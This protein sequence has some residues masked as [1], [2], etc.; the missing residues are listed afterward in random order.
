MTAPDVY[1][2]TWTHRI[3]PRMG[4]MIPPRFATCLD[5]ETAKEIERGITMLGHTDLTVAVFTSADPQGA[6][7]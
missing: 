2:V 1:T 3:D 6:V 4:A 7:A 5:E